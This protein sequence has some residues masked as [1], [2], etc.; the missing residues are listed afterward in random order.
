MFDGYPIYGPYGYSSA[1]NLNSGIKLMV[2]GYKLRTGM[3][4]RDKTSSN[5]AQLSTANQGPVVDSQYPLG[6]FIEGKSI[7]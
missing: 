3:T 2:S 1:N 6:S 7:N 5:G 4:Y